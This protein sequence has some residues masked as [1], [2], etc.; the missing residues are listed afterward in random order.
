M[1]AAPPLGTRPA[2]FLGAFL[3]FQVQ[4][5][6]AKALLPRFGGSPAVWT[7]CMLFF[8]AVLLAGYAYA[9]GTSRSLAPRAQAWLHLGLSALALLCLPIAPRADATG[10]TA[11]VLAILALLARSVALPAFLLSASSPLL[12]SWAARAAGVQAG[13]G[14]YRL[15][16]WSNAGSMLGLV[17]YPLVVE[18]FLPAG[19]QEIAWSGAF[20]GFLLLSAWCAWRAAA[21]GPGAT[22]IDAGAKPLTA[23]PALRQSLTWLALSACSSTLLLA[24]TN[25][26]CQEVA[27]VPLLWVVPL[28]LYLLS[29][30]LPFSGERWYGRA[31]CLPV[32]V[33]ALVAMAQATALGARAG[34]LYAVP[35]YSLGLF[36][37]CLFCHGELA[38]RRPDARHLTAYYLL[39]ALGGA[40]GGVFVSLAA[41][42]LFRGYDELYV[43]LLGCALLAAGVVLKDPARRGRGPRALNPVAPALLVAALLIGLALA[44]RVLTRTRP[45]ITELRSFHGALRIQDVSLPSGA[46]SVRYLTHGRTFH[47]LQF[48]APE[49]RSEPTT[50][51]GRTSGIGILLAELAAEGP[52]RVGIIGLGAGVLAAYGRAGDTYRF[53]ELDPLVIE[54]ARREFTFLSASPAVIE[55]VPGDARLSLEHE[56]DQR[57]DLLV[58][59]AFSS[60]AIPVH[61]LTREAFALYDRHLEP[62]GVLALHV[63]TRHLDLGPLI[64]AQARA[65]GKS[66]WEI[67]SAADEGQGLL[68]AR[69]VLVGTDDSRL[70]RPRIRAAGRRLAERVEPIRP[71]TDDYSN[72]LAVLR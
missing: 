11:P 7:T 45:G 69:W 31:W 17:A 15:Y 36:T 33:L 54:V 1:R 30:L 49:R 57:F 6:S 4:L 61:L 60:D 26:M 10:T 43:G 46:G 34:I 55:V 39:I 35:V 23:L 41:P 21:T 66:A 38:A 29:F 58:L 16:A 28:A 27:V 37:C 40:L 13:S 18:P 25:Q 5:V 52:V 51:F 68:D 22:P 59:D 19:A 3:L 9:H 44:S 48:L 20:A 47:G 32:L 50:Y 65:E 24:T 53:Y 70:A 42:L 56:R 14:A 8:Q 2:V 12:Q 64:E 71:W 72:L 67:L 63:T 62:D